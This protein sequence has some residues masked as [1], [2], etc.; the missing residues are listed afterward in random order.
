MIYKLT[1][2]ETALKEWNKLPPNIQKQFKKKLEERL[3]NPQIPAS[4][5]H[6]LP[7]CYKIK[8]KSAGYRLVYKVLNECVV[9]QVISVGK[10]DKLS[11]YKKALE[12]IH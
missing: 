5:L 6:N 8:L 10:R 2:L 3:I 7:D 12:R 1:F 11:V 4:K 9:V